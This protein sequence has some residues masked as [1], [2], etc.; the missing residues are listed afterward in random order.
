MMLPRD[1]S[2][3]PTSFRRMPQ[4][5]ARDACPMTQRRS[6]PT[7]HLNPDRAGK[8]EKPSA[9]PVLRTARFAPR[10][11]S[12]APDL[13]KP[14]AARGAPED[15][16]LD[17]APSTQQHCQPQR[18]P[19]HQ[20]MERRGSCPAPVLRRSVGNLLTPPEIGEC[21]VPPAERILGSC[22]REGGLLLISPASARQREVERC[23]P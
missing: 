14:G 3:D 12:T 21:S 23:G 20:R 22:C 4:A 19:G 6:S 8:K 5:Q 10:R 2:L 13:S 9:S 11:C 1:R 16:W 18:S 15:Q 7:E 17:R